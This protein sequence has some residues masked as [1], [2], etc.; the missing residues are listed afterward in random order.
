MTDLERVL[1]ARLVEVWRAGA[2]GVLQI[3]PPV[4]PVVL[5][6]HTHMS[7]QKYANKHARTRKRTHTHTH[8]HM[9]W[10]VLCQAEV[11]VPIIIQVK[12]EEGFTGLDALKRGGV[13]G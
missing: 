4:H 7:S 2:P 13:R 11:K 5:P 9:S 12:Q 3:F 10:E 8:T 1:A 6:R